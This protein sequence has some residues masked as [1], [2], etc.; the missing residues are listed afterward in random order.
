MSNF[1]SA[2]QSQILKLKQKLLIGNVFPQGKL[3]FCHPPP[4]HDQ[5]QFN[6]QLL[7]GGRK[8]ERKERRRGGRRGE[9]DDQEESGTSGPSEV[10]K[11]CGW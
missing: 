5:R 4:G 8:E 10:A 1:T 11:T 7:K 2:E 9:D 3:L 6:N